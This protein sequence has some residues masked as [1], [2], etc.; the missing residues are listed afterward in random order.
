MHLLQLKCS[1][2]FVTRE[3]N[4]IKTI[5]ARY[6]ASCVLDLTLVVNMHP[7]FCR[8]NL[9]HDELSMSQ[10]SKQNIGHK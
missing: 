6:A 5:V 8:P 9:T 7:D 10:K 4:G 1:I 2:V 3:E